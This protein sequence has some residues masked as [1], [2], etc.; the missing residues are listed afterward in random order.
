MSNIVMPAVA[1]RRRMSRSSTPPAG[2]VSVVRPGA[3]RDRVIG[4]GERQVGPAHL[5]AGR[6]ES[7]QVGTGLEV[8][9]QMAV[10]V[11]QRDVARQH[12]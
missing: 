12:A 4:R 11:Q 8:V 1:Q 5:D 10:D 2:L 9:D 3:L 6:L 7:R